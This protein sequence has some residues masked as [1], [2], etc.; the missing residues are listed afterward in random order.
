MASGESPSQIYA[1][2]GSC[3]GQERPSSSVPAGLS[4]WLEGSSPR[5]ASS[6]VNTVANSKEWQARNCQSVMLPKTDS[7]ERWSKQCTFTAAW[8][9][10]SANLAGLFY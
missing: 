4:P 3:R 8:E 6:S 9:Y 2:G 5:K 7:F 10:N 1:L